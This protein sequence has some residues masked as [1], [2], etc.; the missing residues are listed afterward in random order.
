MVPLVTLRSSPQLELANEALGGSDLG[1]ITSPK[2]V[3]SKSLTRRSTTQTLTKTRT[4]GAQF[5]TSLNLLMDAL[6]TTVPHFIRCIKPN[7]DKEPFG[8]VTAE[9]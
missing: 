1:S 7:D 2:R 4:V 5:K 9:N 3:A 8:L 6:S